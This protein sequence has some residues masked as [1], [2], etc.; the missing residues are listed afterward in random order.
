MQER[1]IASAGSLVNSSGANVLAIA[2]ITLAYDWF[3]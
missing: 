3:G 2:L 1:D